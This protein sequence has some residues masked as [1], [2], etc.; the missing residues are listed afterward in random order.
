M[1]Q[2]LYEMTHYAKDAERI[3]KVNDVRFLI[4]ALLETVETGDRVE[5][6]DG[7][8]G[9]LLC[10]QNCDNPIMQE[11]FGL[12]ILGRQTERAKKQTTMKRTMIEWVNF[13]NINSNQ[14]FGIK[15]YGSNR[16]S[17]INDYL[18]AEE[19]I[20]TYEGWAN[21]EVVRVWHSNRESEGKCYHLFE[22]IC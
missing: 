14:Y 7:F 11:E 12:M 19:F 15:R 20:K 9:E 21:D 13:L 4:D 3:I 22:V 1:N 16:T 10:A 17:Y 6:I 18:S 5:V 2:Y 8:T